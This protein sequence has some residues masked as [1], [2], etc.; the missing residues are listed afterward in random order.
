MA[1]YD[2][3]V[4]GAG[5]NGLTAAAVL[6]RDGR[7]PSD[8]RCDGTA[9]TGSAGVTF[10]HFADVV[11]IGM[12]WSILVF[13]VVVNTF[14]AVLLVS[15]GSEEVLQGGIHGFAARHFPRLP[16]ESTW[17]LNHD[18][19]GSPH[20]ALLEGEGPIV[21]E[22]YESGFRELVGEIATEAGIPLRRKLRAR[23]STDAVIPHSCRSAGKCVTRKAT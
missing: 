3:I 19:I 12:D 7:R 9:R 16:P 1:D 20:L 22:D 4:I 21:M 10:R 8:A 6:A 23:V 11:L 15:A 14:Y 13:C 18:S 17:F 2:A 5:H